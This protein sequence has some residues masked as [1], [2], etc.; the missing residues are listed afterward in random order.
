MRELLYPSFQRQESH[1]DGLAVAS[2]VEVGQQ[3]LTV[4]EV[5]GCWEAVGA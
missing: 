2:T 3:W 5:G 1:L 4:V